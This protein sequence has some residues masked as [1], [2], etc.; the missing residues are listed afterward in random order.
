[1]ARF[2]SVTPGPSPAD[3]P[4]V[5]VASA[6]RSPRAARRAT[7]PIALIRDALRL[8]TTA[9]TDT[10]PQSPREGAPAAE[11][12]AEEQAL[13][14]EGFLPADFAAL[15]ALAAAQGVDAA[16][17]AYCAGKAGPFS[18]AF[19]H[20]EKMLWAARQARDNP[21]L[22]RMVKSIQPGDILVQTWNNP[23]DPVQAFTKGPFAHA[24]L[25]V[26][27]GPPPEFV[28]AV[29][30]T[31]DPKDPS[32][33]RVRRS[34]LPE[35]CYS[36]LT[37]R[38]VRPTEGMPEPERQRAI[39]RAIAY[40]L[41]QL[42][43]PYDFALTN[44]H[45]NQAYYCSNLVYFA[46]TSPEGA[47]IALPIDKSIDRDAFL[48]AAQSVVDALEPDDS[49]ALAAVVMKRL[50]TKG[51]GGPPSPE[52][53]AGVLVDDIFPNC[54]TTK[55][56][57][58]TEASRAAM[59]QVLAK[60]V[61]G[62]GFDRFKS[63]L[64]RLHR[65]EAAGRFR[66]PILGF[67]R[68]AWEHVKLARALRQDTKTL[69]A[70][71][72]LNQRAFY[73]ASSK[74]LWATLPHS[75][76]FA[77]SLFGVHDSRTQALRGFLDKVDWINASILSKSVFRWLGLGLLPGRAAPGIKTDFVS[78]SDLAWAPLPHWDYNVK[79]G[80]PLDRPASASGD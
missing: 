13:I 57:L 52:L 9:T 15:R 1:M 76:T 3:R 25:C 68:R 29:G 28:E 23:S 77:A 12:T 18:P 34:G 51:I 62:K 53:I 59:K 32:F 35:N 41:R 38:I 72:G 16:R 39:A 22:Y 11:P 31:G 71:S 80:F 26:S 56:L 47:G 55:D 37:T 79:P 50:G 69:L 2:D 42:G 67:F 8:R 70:E 45:I 60:V 27:A 33:N 5:P 21:E 46:Y 19:G 4:A 75:E 36:S 20:P 10:Q 63:A 78:P 14:A 54:R 73:N 58:P 17:A 44:R 74:L 64:D 7:G 24:V 65:D 6:E 48:V 40:V 30:F 49:G 43:K 66:T 61:E